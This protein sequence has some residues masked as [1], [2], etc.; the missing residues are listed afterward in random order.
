MRTIPSDGE[1]FALTLT[2]SETGV[3]HYSWYS[4][5]VDVSTTSP[6]REIR[7][8]S[9]V[10]PSKMAQLWWGLGQSCLV[11]ASATHLALY[12]RFGGN[13]LVERTIVDTAFKDISSPQQVGFAGLLEG[14]LAVGSA[15]PTILQHA[16]T[17]RLRMEIL[18]RDAFRCRVCGRGPRDNVD[19][20]LHV[21]HVL[22]WGEGG[23]T[24]RRNSLRSA[25]RATRGCIRIASGLCS[26][27]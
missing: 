10:D 24:V 22:P 9:Q 1:Y 13:A 20:Q 17:P 8:P 23:L 6:R 11:V 21:H 5:F 3:V 14:P 4:H 26:R 15:D 25:I 19:I 2:A 27:S 18:K 7:K 12:L 16:P